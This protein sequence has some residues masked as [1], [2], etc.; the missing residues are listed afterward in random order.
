MSE[1]A[2][3]PQEKSTPAPRNSNWRNGLL[4]AFG[5]LAFTFLAIEIGLRL[6]GFSYRL[7]PEKIEFG[8]PRPSVMEDRY[9]PDNELLWVP[10]EY[11][12]QLSQLQESKPTLIFM[13]DSCTEFGTYDKFF[14][15]KAKQFGLKEPLT[16]A[17]VGVGGWTSYQGLQQMKRDIAP[18]HPAVVTIY[19]GWNDHWIGF[20]IQDKEI[21]RLRSPLFTLLEHSRFIQLLVKAVISQG[22][23]KK[24][25]MP[26]RVSEEDFRNN[27]RGIVKTAKESGI[28][29]VLLT[30]PSSHQKGKEPGYLKQRH[31]KNLD[32]LIPLHQR[33][34]S[35]VREVAAES[36]VPLCDLAKDFATLPPEDLSKLYF[37]KDGIHLTKEAGGGYDKLAEFLLQCFASQKIL[38]SSPS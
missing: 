25:T 17:K 16:T 12:S 21:G 38:V 23:D 37:N 10:K 26:L 15:E 33:Y 36:K 7:Y 11:Q 8:W 35:I 14:S 2:P 1:A 30:A 27:L 32:E 19:Y 18:L 22:Q 31:L 3:D 24:N 9:T 20:G 34:V 6:W 13:G 4:M 29:P 28:T 5:S